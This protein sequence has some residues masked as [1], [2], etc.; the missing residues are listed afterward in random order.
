MLTTG[1][2]LDADFTALRSQ[3]DGSLVHPGDETWD[4]ARQA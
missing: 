2:P 1:R 3:L 4:A